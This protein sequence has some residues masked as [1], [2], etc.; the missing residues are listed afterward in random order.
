MLKEYGMV[1]IDSKIPP[2]LAEA[3][4]YSGPHRWIG[5]IDSEPMGG[6]VYTDGTASGICDIRGWVLFSCNPHITDIIDRA[7]EEFKDGSPALVYDREQSTLHCIKNEKVDEFLSS[8]NCSP[9]ITTEE[10]MEGAYS[11]Y[12]ANL[13][14]VNE[15]PAFIDNAILRMQEWMMSNL[16]P[17]N[18]AV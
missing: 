4:G 6:I 15:T 7:F 9:P 14:G 12:I 16:A 3:I 8:E 5:I 17:P 13:F 11:D 2:M 10:Q 18:Q 1:Q